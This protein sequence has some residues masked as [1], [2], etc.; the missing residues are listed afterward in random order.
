MR[1][2]VFNLYMAER[3]RQSALGHARFN[4]KNAADIISNLMTWV[5]YNIG[6]IETNLTC[7][8]LKA[9]F[10]RIDVSFA[11]SH[12]LKGH[13]FWRHINDLLEYD[14]KRDLQGSF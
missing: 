7:A 1:Y 10:A 2:G 11:W 13:E 8:H 6:Y 4:E 12:S 14:A 9:E 5:E 3:I